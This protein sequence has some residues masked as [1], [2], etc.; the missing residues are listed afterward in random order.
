MKLMKKVKLNNKVRIIAGKWR[1]RKLHFANIPDLR[2]TS[3]RMRET[4]F[5]WLAPYIDKAH[6]LDLFAGSGALGFEA[7]SRG[8]S[9]VVMIDAERKV[10]QELKTNQ[11]LLNAENLEIINM[12]AE[13]YLSQHHK[14]AFDIIFLDPPFKKQLISNICQ[15]IDKNKLLKPK[16]YIYIETN[17]ALS[18]GDLPTNWQITKQKQAGKVLYYLAKSNCSKSV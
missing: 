10:I 6:C 17:A 18:T 4:L 7:L 13:K 8:A 2:P 11:K 3:D 9:K 12:E 15:L 14:D 1:S 16:G 5:N